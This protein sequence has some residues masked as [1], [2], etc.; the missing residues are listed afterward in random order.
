MSNRILTFCSVV[1]ALTAF[2]VINISSADAQRTS[3]NRV[4]GSGDSTVRSTP[5][6]LIRSASGG[7]DADANSN[8]SVKPT[9]TATSLTTLQKLN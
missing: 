7:S 3:P 4:T 6:G 1:T 9:P 2:S 5:R 8:T